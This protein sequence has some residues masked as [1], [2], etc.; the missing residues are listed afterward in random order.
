M[1]DDLIFEELK[2]ST[3]SGSVVGNSGSL[4]DHLPSCVF[5]EWLHVKISV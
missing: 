3:K 4:T 2:F 1:E 5:C